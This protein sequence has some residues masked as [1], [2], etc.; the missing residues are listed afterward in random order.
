MAR[1]FSLVVMI[2][3]IILM[4]PAILAYVSNDAIPTNKV[5]YPIKRALENGILA[6]ASLHPTSKAWFSVDRS[7]RRFKESKALLAT[8]NIPFETLNELVVQTQEAKVEISRISESSERLKLFEEYKRSISEY[9]DGLVDAKKDVEKTLITPKPP[10]QT[11]QPVVTPASTVTQSPKVTPSASQPQVIA[12]PLPIDQAIVIP[13]PQASTGTIVNPAVP[14]QCRL[15]QDPIQCYIDLLDQ[16]AKLSAD[17]L[18]NTNPEGQPIL[19]P[20][21][22]PQEIAD[23]AGLDQYLVDLSNLNVLDISLLLPD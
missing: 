10:Q 19:D 4:P 9:K 11:P 15:A 6:I 14:D 20:S 7:K 8:G 3:G 2:L 17:Q 21:E 18:P 23:E 16:L 5:R 12:T 13:P 22:L 1:V